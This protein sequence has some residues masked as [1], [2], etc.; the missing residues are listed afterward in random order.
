MLLLVA[1]GLAITFVVSSGWFTDA[2]VVAYLR[3]DGGISQ[4]YESRAMNWEAGYRSLSS[5]GL[6]GFGFISKFAEQGTAT[7]M[8]IAIPQYDWNMESDPLNMIML[9]SRQ[10]GIPGGLFLLAMLVAI[11]RGISR[12]P[13]AES[14][15]ARGLLAAGLIFGL[16]DGNWLTS[17]GDPVDRFSFVALSLLVSIPNESAP[18][19]GKLM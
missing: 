7:F 10:T 2:G 11:F 18:P 14:H 8:G 12:M 1:L 9:T 17:F 16:A 5:Y 4:M 6:F 15:L 3:V 19:M 13:G